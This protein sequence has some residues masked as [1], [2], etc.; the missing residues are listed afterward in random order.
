MYVCNVSAMQ[1]YRFYIAKNIQIFPTSQT[2][3]ILYIYT[4]GFAAVIGAELFE[5][6]SKNRSHSSVTVVH[7]VQSRDSLC[8]QVRAISTET[9]SAILCLRWLAKSTCV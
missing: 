4:L 9:L 2:S 5:P 6:S 8:Q 7:F 3:L 1:I